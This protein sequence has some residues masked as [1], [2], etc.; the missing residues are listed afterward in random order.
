MGMPG[1]E[2]GDSAWE[3]FW[4]QDIDYRPFMARLKT[5]LMED[6]MLAESGMGEQ[7]VSV[8]DQ[9]YLFNMGTTH[10]EMAITGDDIRVRFEETMHE[11]DP[12]SAPA[13]MMALEDMPLQSFNLVDDGGFLMY[14][15]M[16]HV[17]AKALIQVDEIM[18]QAE[19]AEGMEG[20]FGEMFGDMDIE[21]LEQTMQL[22]KAM[23]ID[24]I[25]DSTLSGEVAVALYDMPELNALIEGENVMPTD[26]TA[27]VALGIK[28]ADYVREMIGTYGSEI[29]MTPRTDS[30]MNGWDVFDVPMMPGMGVLMNDS[31]L[32]ATTNADY[33]MGKL[34]DEA[35]MGV[36]ACQVHFVLNMASLNEKV[37]QPGMK[38]LAT[39]AT[40]GN[41]EIYWPID[42]MKYL[43]DVPEQDGLGYMSVT[44]AYGDSASC[45]MHMKKAVFQYLAYYLSTIGAGVIQNEM[46]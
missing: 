18:R 6:Q 25:V 41:E 35:V 13:R 22:M 19:N 16:H 27:A 31:L 21:E 43:W 7:I 32:I 28:D 37:V 34:S 1:F 15:G 8:L 40:D 30:G 24:K 14:L 4:V 3:E 39:E 9:M 33:V 17:P 10:T 5:M 23:Q 29:G 11:L 2:M 45:E 36:D 44:N 38:L 42:S 26:F 46:H 12:A 20:L